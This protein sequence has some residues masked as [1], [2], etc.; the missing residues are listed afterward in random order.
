M[1]FIH[2]FYMFRQYSWVIVF[3]NKF[4]I[5][6]SDDIPSILSYSTF[7]G[8][9]IL[10]KLRIARVLVSSSIFSLSQ[11]MTRI[12]QCKVDK[13]QKL[14]NIVLSSDN[15]AIDQYFNEIGQC[16]INVE[17]KM[18]RWMNQ[19]KLQNDILQNEID[20]IE[21]GFVDTRSASK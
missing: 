15:E 14:Q 20:L 2:Q 3:F 11:N 5:K 13:K 21:H 10:D 1:T 19:L 6:S 18:K 16:I 7:T 12:V 8:R 4:K 17:C 9:C